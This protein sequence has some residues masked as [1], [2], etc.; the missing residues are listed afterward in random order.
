MGQIGL[1]RGRVGAIAC[2][3]VS[4]STLGSILLLHLR[5]CCNNQDSSNAN[6]SC[7][8]AALLCII[9]SP[10]WSTQQEPQPEIIAC[11]DLDTLLAAH[12]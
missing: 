2:I 7:Y 3:L 4:Y 8:S 11:V 1:P 9:F 5:S 10:I 12:R 6:E